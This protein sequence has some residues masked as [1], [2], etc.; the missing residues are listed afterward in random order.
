MRGD[1]AATASAIAIPVDGRGAR[2]EEGDES[3]HFLDEIILL[4][5]VVVGGKK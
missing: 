5:Y 1:V 3:A 4:Y 2:E